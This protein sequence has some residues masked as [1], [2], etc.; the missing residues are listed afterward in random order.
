MLPA[1]YLNALLGFVLLLFGRTLYWIFVAFAGFLMG[2]YL[3]DVI[4]VG[5]TEQTRLVVGL[6]FGG[7]GA[8]LAMAAQRIAFA[9]GGFFAGGYLAAALAGA[10]PAD[11]SGWLWLLVGGIVG[12]VVAAV[13]M[14]WAIVLLSSLAGA[15]VIVQAMGQ[16]PV[17]STIA[18][19]VLVLIGLSFQARGLAR[20]R[21]D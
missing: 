5:A 13:M 8:V 12:A 2:L 14:D 15:G 10:V 17:L 7:L 4:V 3:A 19:V 20:R 6:L 21:A 18:Y 1:P 11:G 16:D 9:V